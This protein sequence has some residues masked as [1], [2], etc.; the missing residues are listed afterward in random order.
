MITVKLLG[1]TLSIK[2][3]PEEKTALKAS[4]RYYNDQAEQCRLATPFAN[5]ENLS[6]ITALNITRQYLSI[7]Q[8]PNDEASAIN[9]RIANLRKNIKAAL[10]AEATTDAERTEA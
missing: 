1:R 5:N 8:H 3:P 10:P 7:K 2:C 4:V 9:Q 6:I